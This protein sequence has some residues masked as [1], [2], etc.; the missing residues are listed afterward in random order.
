MGLAILCAV[1]ATFAA[2]VVAA[3]DD[4][5]A[6]TAARIHERALTIDTHVDTPMRLVGKGFD[7]GV[8][9]DT[10]RKVAEWTCHA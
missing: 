10:V 8:R 5:L 9:H 6:N 1:I 2:G 4:G 3:E 7:I